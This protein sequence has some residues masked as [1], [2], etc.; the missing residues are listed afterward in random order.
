[1]NSDLYF[2][3]CKDIFDSVKTMIGKM[4]CPQEHKKMMINCY[5]VGLTISVPLDFTSMTKILNRKRKTAFPRIKFLD[6]VCDSSGTREI[7]VQD[8]CL[9]FFGMGVTD[10]LYE[11]RFIFH[12]VP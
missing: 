2:E 12:A 8:L 3:K 6:Y 7:D 1:M 11:K 4:D 5:F 9:R 10:C